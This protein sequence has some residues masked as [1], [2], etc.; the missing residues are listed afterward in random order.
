[1][2][3]TSKITSIVAT[4]IAMT[5][6]SV[7]AQAGGRPDSSSRN[8]FGHVSGGYALASG[9]TG[10]ALDDD[11]TIGG[12]ALYWPAS[13]PIGISL[14]VN[15]LK[16][17]LSRSSINAIN[18]AIAS[19]PNNDGEISGGDFDNLQFALNGI[20]SLGPETNRGLY[21]TA[22]ISYNSVTGRIF[23]EGLV[24][25][26]P[27]CDPWYWWWCYPGGVGPG[28]LVS[29]KRSDNEFG[30]NVG[31][32]YSFET[33]SG[34]LFVEAR[35]QQIQVGDENIEYIPLVVGYRW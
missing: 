19:D 35:Y 9:D 29:D 26:P 6:A 34:Q 21:L 27:I 4:L 33:M 18:D 17:D 16:M 10:D 23:E 3:S 30:W 32:G 28:E 20:W 12:G 2:M 31:A 25:Y 8:W 13:W 7:S 14:D 24:Y 1:M 15:Y 5:L 11:W 22:G